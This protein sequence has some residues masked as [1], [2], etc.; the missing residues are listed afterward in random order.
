[1]ALKTPRLLAGLIVGAQSAFVLSV[2][3]GAGRG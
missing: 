3:S 1:V 2:R